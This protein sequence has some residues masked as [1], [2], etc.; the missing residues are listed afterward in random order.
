MSAPDVPESG[1][2]SGQ[3]RSAIHAAAFAAIGCDGFGNHRVINAKMF[4]AIERILADRTAALTAE[5]DG[6]RATVDR[7]R[8]LADE[9]ESATCITDG[10][11]C[12]FHRQAEGYASDLRA[13]LG[14]ES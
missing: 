7:V 14:E 8:A 1:R 9:W 5:L 12:S 3:E 4:T 2:L 10:A 6:L 13:V 11:P